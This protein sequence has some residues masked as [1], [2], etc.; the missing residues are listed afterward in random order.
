MNLMKKALESDD[1]LLDIL[2]NDELDNKIS[3]IQNNNSDI[4]NEHDSIE[5][6]ISVVNTTTT[7]A[8]SIEK[9]ID[10]DNG[11]NVIDC[12]LVTTAMEHFY[13]QTNYTGKAINTVSLESNEINYKEYAKLALE[14]IN[15]FNCKLNG[16]LNIAQEGFISNIIDSI[17]KVFSTYSSLEN[18]LK[19][20]HDSYIKNGSNDKTFNNPGWGRIFKAFD[21]NGNINKLITELQDVE[22]INNDSFTKAVK[23]IIKASEF[24]KENFNKS[25]I[26]V[27]RRVMEDLYD[28]ASFLN[29]KNKRMGAYLDM[30]LKD[31]YERGKNVTVYFKALTKDEEKKLYEISLKLI[32]NRQLKESYKPLSRINI[33]MT[34]SF[35]VTTG[36]YRQ[37]GIE[38]ASFI[39]AQIQKTMLYIYQLY[40]LNMNITHSTIKYIEASTK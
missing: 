14:E 36:E 40:S 29:D 18:N 17:G 22:R 1:S 28:V 38:H 13:L 27:D 5:N 39:K 2:G 25:R 21:D 37:D 19:K 10:S 4:I 35:L 7:I 11:P 12:E 20:A 33:D 9:S 16:Q 6:G 32:T 30:I 24:F 15:D 8:N 23:E 3:D 26:T 31:N 34:N